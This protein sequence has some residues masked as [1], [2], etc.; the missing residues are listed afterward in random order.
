MGNIVSPAQ[1]SKVSKLKGII[2]LL[3]AQQRKIRNAR[4]KEYTCLKRLS[5]R[6]QCLTRKYN[7]SSSNGD[8][9]EMVEDDMLQVDGYVYLVCVLRVLSQDWGYLL[10]VSAVDG[11]IRASISSDAY[12]CVCQCVLQVCLSVTVYL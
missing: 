7:T 6:M 11:S 10:F 9:F 4:T 8:R 1:Q 12:L 3:T 5:N 2:T